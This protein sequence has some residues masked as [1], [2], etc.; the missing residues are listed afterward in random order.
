MRIRVADEFSLVTISRGVPQGSVLGLRKRPP[1]IYSVKRYLIEDDVN[2]ICPPD[3][4]D[5]LADDLRKDELK[6]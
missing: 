5:T 4:I 3:E 1:H 6:C 2:L